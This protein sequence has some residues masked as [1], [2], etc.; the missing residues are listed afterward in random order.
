[1]VVTSLHQSPSDLSSSPE[2]PEEARLRI[3][4][5]GFFLTAHSRGL[6]S[7]RDG[8]PRGSL[9]PLRSRGPTWNQLAYRNPSPIGETEVDCLMACW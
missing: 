2:I 9:W 7:T 1:V 5:G 6:E 3:D 8:L 4:I